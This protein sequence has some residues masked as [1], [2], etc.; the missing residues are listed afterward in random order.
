MFNCSTKQE[1]SILQHLINCRQIPAHLSPLKFADRQMRKCI[2]QQY[3]LLVVQWKW[4]YSA[5]NPVCK[6]EWDNN[7]Y[8]HHSN[9]FNFWRVFVESRLLLRQRSQAALF[10]VFF[11]NNFFILLFCLSS[12]A[13]AKPVTLRVSRCRISLFALCFLVQQ[14]KVTQPLKW[15]GYR[16]REVFGPMFLSIRCW[17]SVRKL[18]TGAKKR[19]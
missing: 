12:Q 1:P 10:G 8:Y 3:N 19:D 7:K 16:I 4:N 2:R 18:L 5:V 9:K 13:T 6:P 11:F 15:K 14:K 17:N